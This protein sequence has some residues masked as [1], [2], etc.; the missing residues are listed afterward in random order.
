MLWVI[1]QRL[2]NLLLFFCCMPHCIGQPDQFPYKLSYATDISLISGAVSLSLANHHIKKNTD[3]QYLTFEEIQR[4]NVQDIPKFDR[5]VTQYWSDELADLSDVT[6]TFLNIAPAMLILPPFSDEKLRN[7]CVL[8]LMYLEGS[9]INGSITDITKY[10]THRKRPYLYNTNTITPEEKRWL[11]QP[12]CDYTYTSFFSGHTSEAF[13]S[14]VFLSKVV[15]DICGKSAITFVVWGT[16][17]SG[18]VITGYLRY[19]SGWHYPSDI[20]AG[21]IA[22]CAIGYLIPVLHKNRKEDKFRLSFTGNQIGFQYT[23]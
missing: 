12:G 18:A 13:Y 16:A 7:I 22:G 4:L 19:K 5:S 17:L 1:K 21:A 8:A 9:S 20:L 14:A 11:S 10:L 6:R 23:F 3:L 2:M 15:Y